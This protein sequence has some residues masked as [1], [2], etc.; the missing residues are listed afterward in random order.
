MCEYCEKTFYKNDYGREF[1][2]LFPENTYNT[3]VQISWKE[4]KTDYNIYTN[5]DNLAYDVSVPIHFCP[6]CGRKFDQTLGDCGGKRKYGQINNRVWRR[7]CAERYVQYRQI[8][9]S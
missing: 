1:G 7:V 2:K 5:N 9:R 3:D 6:M 8:R 4:D